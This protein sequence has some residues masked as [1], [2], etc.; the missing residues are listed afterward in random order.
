MP[1]NQEHWDYVLYGKR[2]FFESLRKI[3]EVA[4][5]VSDS[6]DQ[7]VFN[8]YFGFDILHE[9]TA[10]I[11]YGF[12]ACSDHYD[13]EVT[14]SFY[15]FYKNKHYYLHLLPD[16]LKSRI[17]N[18]SAFKRKHAAHV[19]QFKE[20]F[21]R[22]SQLFNALQKYDPWKYFSELPRKQKKAGATFNPIYLVLS[23][24][25]QMKLYKNTTTALSGDYKSYPL[26]TKSKTIAAITL[27]PLGSAFNMNKQAP[28]Y[29][30]V[31]VVYG[32]PKEIV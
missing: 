1:T 5:R 25:I 19:N 29:G 13:H 21:G 31:E 26:S 22:N 32:A 30:R 15:G 18:K 11:Y 20:D 9:N 27:Y 12:L 17:K 8:T 28:G 14:D 23:S 24:T 10:S 6:E 16:S 2:L 7:D 4:S 3:Q